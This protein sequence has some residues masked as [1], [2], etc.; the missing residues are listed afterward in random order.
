MLHLKYWFWGISY[1]AVWYLVYSKLISSVCEMQF[2]QIGCLRHTN[3]YKVFLIFDRIDQMAGKT[4]NRKF[5][6]RFADVFGKLFK[7]K[8][9]PNLILYYRLYCTI[10]KLVSFFSCNAV[11]RIDYSFLFCLYN[12]CSRVMRKKRLIANNW[13]FS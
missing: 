13:L 5:T 1:T 10:F 2:I 3:F 4:I 11:I 12:I 6:F 8:K 9:K 7:S